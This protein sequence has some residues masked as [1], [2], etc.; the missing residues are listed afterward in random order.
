MV[1]VISHTLVI[2]I[3]MNMYIEHPQSLILNFK[4][5]H[6][7]TF[8]TSYTHLVVAKKSDK[9]LYTDSAPSV[10]EILAMDG[11]VS[12]YNIQ[13]YICVSGFVTG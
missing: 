1:A 12:L 9:D 3:I 13:N 8:Q 7:P 10:K 5:G 11:E 4:K 2:I 6:Y